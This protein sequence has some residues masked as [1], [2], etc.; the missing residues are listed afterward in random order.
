MDGSLTRSRV[1]E[2][3]TAPCSGLTPQSMR[4]EC[5]T[6][7]RKGVMKT[8]CILLVI[9]LTTATVAMA[10]IRVTD[11]LEIG[12]SEENVSAGV[13]TLCIDGQ[14]FVFVFGWAKKGTVRG[15]GA[16]GGVSIV[17]VYEEKDGVV[18]PAKCE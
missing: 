3:G 12:E 10:D 17:Q 1:T 6:S 13:H 4:I 5:I 18:V 8:I 15:A 2:H 16:G 11:R 14:K 7:E 9:L